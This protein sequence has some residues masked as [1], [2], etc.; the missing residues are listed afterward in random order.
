MVI[1][2]QLWGF[3]H[4]LSSALGADTLRRDWAETWFASWFTP[5]PTLSTYILFLS[6][7]HFRYC[8]AGLCFYSSPWPF[9]HYPLLHRAQKIWCLWENRPWKRLLKTK[10]R[11]PHPN[12]ALLD[13]EWKAFNSSCIFKKTFRKI[14]IV[15]RK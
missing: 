1:L 12:H 2:K 8:L 4:N 6:F 13:I 11:E 10:D 3:P 14:I 9:F 5:S 7:F 15:P